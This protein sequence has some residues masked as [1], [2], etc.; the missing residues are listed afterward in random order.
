[1][2][3][4]RDLIG[5][6]FGLL[7]VIRRA[8]NDEQG[9]VCW[10]CM[11]DCGNPNPRIVRGQNLINGKTIS[12][13][14]IKRKKEA[15]NLVG[16]KFGML[17]VISRAE[18]NIG[19]DGK[20]VIM[21]NCVCECGNKTIVDGRSLKKGHTKS[22]GCLQGE[23]HND[24]SHILGKTRLYRIWTN[25][26]QR[27]YN[28]N[29]SNFKNYGAKGVTICEEWKNSYTKFKEWATNN[30][31]NDTLTV[32]RINVNDNYYPENCRWISLREQENNKSVNHFIT[33]NGETLTLAE[34][35]RKLGFKRGVLEYRLKKGWDIE[36]AIT[37]PLMNRHKSC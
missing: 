21:W 15:K 25:M 16:M 9:R 8:D 2:A 18:D 35:N 34:W 10:V 26:K 33:F 17:S 6:Q 28:P 37:T 19:N 3:K 4:L 7:T 20:N 27:C 14:C 23:H 32:D 24:S 11:C 30:G 22:C 31:Y 1:M 36:K 5:E 29:N 13:G 12:C